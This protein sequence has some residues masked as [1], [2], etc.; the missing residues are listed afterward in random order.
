MTANTDTS[1][2]TDLVQSDTTRDT[3]IG[4]SSW[5]SC[6]AGSYWPAD[7]KYLKKGKYY[8]HLDEID[9][10]KKNGKWYNSNYFRKQAKRHL[11][12]AISSQLD[13]TEAQ[14][15]KAF[16]IFMKGDLSEW[17]IKMEIVA[18]SL[19]AYLV[20][21]DESDIRKCHPLS[22][23]E[24]EKRFDEVANS[25]DISSSQQLSTYGKIQARLSGH[26]GGI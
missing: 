26:R 22:E 13:L 8:Q 10:G 6:E 1:I 18:W 17:G 14:Y 20:H 3:Y 25:L 11:F 7:F 16:S 9:A 24:S 4:W 5:K 23:S 12:E 19:C 15:S 2:T 21:S